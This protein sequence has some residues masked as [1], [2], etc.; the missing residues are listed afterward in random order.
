MGLGF[1]IIFF[2]VLAIV[3][4]VAQD[5]EEG[6]QQQ[7]I[8]I[9]GTPIKY[10]GGSPYINVVSNGNLKSMSEGIGFTYENGS[11]PI[12][13][14]WENV[15]SLELKT[16]EQITKDVTA[17]RV[18]LLGVFAL[19]AQK[20]NVHETQYLVI[21]CEEEGVPYNAVFSG[22]GIGGLASRINGSLISY[23]KAHKEIPAS[24]ANTDIAT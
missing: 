21:N 18:L 22:N 17:G 5:Y 13:T 9:K 3:L 20:S 15:K 24:D 10:L 4:I 2:V 6:K 23:R 19:G 1:W 14:P 16:H 11:S 7:Q 12:I 8:Q